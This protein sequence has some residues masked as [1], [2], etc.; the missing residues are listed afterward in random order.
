VACCT[1]ECLVKVFELQGVRRGT[2]VH[3]T[4]LDQARACPLDRVKPQFK[5]DLPN[6]LW[7]SD[8]TYAS[9]WQGC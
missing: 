9:I 8:F 1:V 2:V 3:T 6:Q 4:I 7:V 5:A